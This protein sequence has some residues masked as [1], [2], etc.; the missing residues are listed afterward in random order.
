MLLPVLQVLGQSNSVSGI[1]FHPKRE[2]RIAQ[3]AGTSGP[4]D[5]SGSPVRLRSDREILPRRLP[6]P[7]TP[8]PLPR[9]GSFPSADRFALRRPHIVMQSINFCV[10]EDRTLIQ[11]VPFGSRMLKKRRLLHNPQVQ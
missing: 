5:S 3:F 7:A 10:V 1:R 4:P 2:L 11:A 8:D 6:G 9:S